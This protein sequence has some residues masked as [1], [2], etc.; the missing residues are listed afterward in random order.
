MHC[1]H[2]IQGFQMLK[3]VV[4]I[5]ARVAEMLLNWGIAHVT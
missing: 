2:N 5:V 4:H 1:A 3:E